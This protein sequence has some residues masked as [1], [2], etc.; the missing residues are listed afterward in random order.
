MSVDLLERIE[1]EHG[2]AAV[3]GSHAEAPPPAA[4]PD[5]RAI[6]HMFA[7]ELEPE[8]VPVP[9]Q[10]DC[11]VSLLPMD[12]EAHA[13]YIQLMQP[14][15]DGKVEI[16]RATMELMLNTVVDYQFTRRKRGV[17]DPDT[18]VTELTRPPGGVKRD[19]AHWREFTRGQFKTFTT[20]MRTWLTTECMRVNGMTGE[21]QGN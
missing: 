16:A 13:N 9:G 12:G 15:A 7:S 5:P 1:A 17:N 4:Q 21:Q 3:N 6:A 14:G 11:W 8:I 18:V 19:S 2:A 10:A 20:P